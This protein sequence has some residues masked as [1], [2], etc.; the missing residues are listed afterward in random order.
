MTREAAGEFDVKLAPLAEEEFPGGARL[1]RY[2]LEKV[3]RGDL[4]GAA[5]GEMLTATTAV[6]GSAGYVAVERFG[7][8]LAGRRGSFVLQ[9]LGSMAL[10]AQELL[11]K[12]VP[13]SGTGELTGLAGKLAIRIADGKHY[14]ELEYTLPGQ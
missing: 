12:V 14:Y 9:H 8:A 2:A 4:E 3:Y 13:G 6:E 10:G 7:G 1:G 5:R 11:I